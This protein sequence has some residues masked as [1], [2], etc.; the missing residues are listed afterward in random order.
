LVKGLLGNGPM[1]LQLLVMTLSY[2]PYELSSK[3]IIEVL[4]KL[5]EE[6]L[7]KIDKFKG[8]WFVGEPIFKLDVMLAL[9]K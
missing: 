1:M 6:G 9:V 4:N 5:N 3:E 2:V 7:L 8:Y